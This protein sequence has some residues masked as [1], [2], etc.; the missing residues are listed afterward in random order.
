MTS[1]RDR[2][3]CAASECAH[4]ARCDRAF[5]DQIRQKAKDAKLPVS[6]MQKMECYEAKTESLNNGD[7]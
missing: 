5:S 7:I 6:I 2:T 1:Y 3:Y 4:F